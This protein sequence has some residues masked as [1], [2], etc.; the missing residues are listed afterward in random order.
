MCIC[1]DAT[2]V[3]FVALPA[4]VGWIVLMIV[5]LRGLWR[6][7][8]R[9]LEIAG[10]RLAVTPEE[11]AALARAAAPAVASAQP[12]PAPETHVG[13]AGAKWT[14]PAP[15]V[16]R[17]ASMRDAL[18]QLAIGFA[19][20]AVPLLFAIGVGLVLPHGS[21][22]FQLD[23]WLLLWQGVC[24]IAECVGASILFHAA[25]RLRQADVPAGK[26]PEAG[27]ARVAA[28]L[29]LGTILL[30]AAVLFLL[31][32]LL[33]SGRT[34]PYTGLEALV[35]IRSLLILAF[36]AA[37]GWTLWQPR[38]QIP[39]HARTV[40]IMATLAMAAII[41][42]QF[43]LAVFIALGG[44]AHA[45]V[46]TGVFRNTS[47][48]PT[49]VKVFQLFMSPTI[50]ALIGLCLAALSIAALLAR[51][52]ASPSADMPLPSAPAAG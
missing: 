18:L 28:L 20:M 19:L 21:P 35:T 36:A 44:G 45:S 48:I 22:Q 38:H 43:L 32:L 17:P 47:F 12:T 4:L 13:S 6:M 50:A 41:A 52:P 2:L 9:A 1:C 14:E 30:E 11:A 15:L 29:L 40:F 3:R 27:W 23:W 31:P 7:R 46:A 49:E 8:S 25:R 42:A 26:H 37:V 5:I 16:W 39:H 51:P 10:V 33:I 24:L 34:L